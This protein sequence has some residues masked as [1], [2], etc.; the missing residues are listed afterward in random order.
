MEIQYLD[1][2]LNNVGGGGG[3]PHNSQRGM[4]Q[5]HHQGGSASKDCSNKGG[6]I[7]PG[8]STGGQSKS[9]VSK[10]TESS[11]V[12]YQ[13]VDFVKTEALSKIRKYT[14]NNYKNNQT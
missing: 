1:L 5:A 9:A 4:F 8:I 10:G 6:D 3:D 7:D 13:T 14:E 2:D 11:K 12:E